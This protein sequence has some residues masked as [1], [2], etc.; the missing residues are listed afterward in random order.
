MVVYPI[1]GEAGVRHALE[2][3]RSAD[4]IVK[5]S[6]VGVFDALL[7]SAVLRTRHAMRWRFSGMSMRPRRSTGW[8]R[9]RRIRSV[10]WC[11][12]TTWS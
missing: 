11:R 4:I 5:T 10:R 6:G 12:S 3:A 1:D 7:E 8:N 2:E 9:I